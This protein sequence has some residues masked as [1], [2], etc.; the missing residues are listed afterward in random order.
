MASHRPSIRVAVPSILLA[1]VLAGGSAVPAIAQDRTSPAV[2]AVLGGGGQR[3]LPHLTRVEPR[4]ART[5]RPVTHAQPE[6]RP[7]TPS[8]PVAKPVAIARTD[9]HVSAT[10]TSTPATSAPHAGFHGRNHV[11]IPSLGVDRSVSFFSCSNSSYPGNRVYRWG[12]AGTDNVY[13]FGHAGS[14]FG[15]LHDAYVSGRL[16]KGMAVWYADGGGVVHRYTVRWWKVTTPDDGAWAYAAQSQPSL[17]LQTCVG[18][19][20][21]YRLIVRLVESD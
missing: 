17:T 16:H 5:A 7:P 13:L 4:A 20:S 11:W 12:C 15:P 3:T 19:S 8:V 2:G 21:Q 18:A 6:V 1:F 14:V 9:V 10:S